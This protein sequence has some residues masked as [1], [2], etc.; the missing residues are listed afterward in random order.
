[1]VESR[2]IVS[3]V[4]TGSRAGCPG[5]AEE[6]SAHSVELADVAPAEAA[7][8]RAQGGG[9][10]HGEAQDAA[11]ATGPERIRVVD[12]VAAGERR[13]DEAQELV[14]WVRPTRHQPEVEVLVD[15]GLQAEV[16]GQGGRQEEARVGHQAVVVEGRVKPVEAVR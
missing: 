8:E 11:R 15:E 13:Q 1:M 7:Q 3:G 6:L 12:A 10:L 9:G 14:A 5:A 16:V 2:S 4:D